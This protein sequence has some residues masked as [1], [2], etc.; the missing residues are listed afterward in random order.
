MSSSVNSSSTPL[1]AN[2][3]FTGA[4][5]FLSSEKHGVQAICSTD[6]SGTLLIEFSQNKIDINYTHTFAIE[7]DVSFARSVKKKGNYYRT[8]LNNGPSPQTTL[9]LVSIIE[10]D[11][12]PDTLDVT[13]DAATSSITMFGTDDTGTK[14][15]VKTSSTGEL[16]ISGGGG[17]GGGDASAANQIASNLALCARLDTIDLTLSTTVMS[18][19]IDNQITGFA[20]SLLQESSNIAQ[21]TKLNLIEQGTEINSGFLQTIDFKLTPLQKG[22]ATYTIDAIST[23]SVGT[24]PAYKAPPAGIMA[25]EGW[26]YKNLSAGNASQLYYYGNNATQTQNHDYTLSSI[27][28]Q[29]A[30]VRYLSLN[31]RVGLAYLV[32]YTQPQG[33]GDF[34]PGFA[35]S[36]LIYQI[37]TGQDLRLGEKVV[38]YRGTEP[39]LRIFPE[40]RRVQCTLTVSNGPCLS[41]ELLAYAS[42][43]SDSASTVGDAEYIVGGAGLSFAGDHVYKVELTGESSVVSAGDASSANQVASNTA[44]CTRLDNANTTV[45]NSNLALASRLTTISSNIGQLYY[46]GS[47]LLVHDSQVS[48]EIASLNST[49]GQGISVVMD[50]NPPISGGMRLFGAD[51]NLFVYDAQCNATAYGT[52]SEIQGLNTRLDGV[53]DGTSQFYVKID[54]A[55]DAIQIWGYSAVDSMPE[56]IYTT[57]HAVQAYITNSCVTV[58]GVVGLSEGAQVNLVNS[59]V[60]LIENTV[61]GL[62]G[63][64][65][66]NV[67]NFPSDYATELTLDAIKDQTDLL[68]FSSKDGLNALLVKVDNQLTSPF[69]TTET[70]PV[71]SLFAKLQD[72]SENGISSTASES[73]GNV[74]NTALFAYDIAND[75]TRPVR[76]G[77][78]RGLFI[79]NITSVDFEVVA[80]NDVKVINATG[81]SLDVHCFGSS[82]GTTFHH[83]K[84]SATGELVTHSQTR[85]GTGNSIT[86]TVNGGITALDVAVSGTT[87]ISGVVDSRAQTAFM[88]SVIENQ[89]VTGLVQIGTTVDIE[90]FLW[91][92]AI[93]KFTSVTNGGN[94]FLEV[95][96]D[97]NTW[98]RPSGAQVFIN[99]SIT[100][101][102]GAILLSSPVSM[103]YVR[104]VADTGFIGVSCTA[105][106]C[107]K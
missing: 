85:D 74:L 68:T 20:T 98:A 50:S 72:S 70:N 80:K 89:N 83:L 84:T 14:R 48:S 7:V 43:N 6:A 23:L 25:S 8:I 57:D 102:T 59:T 21:W 46:L 44:I 2:T 54:G 1:A 100:N 64:S 19:E 18:V 107:C 97:S 104:L 38:I 60:G 12:E 51:S 42:L 94:I 16:V 79:E 4:W 28:S 96:P 66:L 106:V 69:S 76:M 65:S 47:N 78:N 81:T 58:S 99:T 13:L 49:I 103:R 92:S 82:D 34:I 52:Y 105:Y 22:I 71:T 62:A 11:F 10:T 61:V 26:Y 27:E 24:T 86:S 53:I 5:E 40:L 30:V 9:Q 77:E 90:H 56:A 41:T 88:P 3:S 95:S 67:D 35:R 29:W 75:V 31:S 73:N 93:L 45:T 87:T 17:G 15:A 55:D 101:T 37:A 39:D 33:T 91:I 36:R 32:V 63:G